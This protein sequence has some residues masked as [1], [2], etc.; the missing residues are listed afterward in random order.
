LYALD[1]AAG[2]P[3]WQ[4]SITDDAAIRDPVVVDGVAYVITHDGDLYAVQC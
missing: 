1:A 4:F 2:D 3:R